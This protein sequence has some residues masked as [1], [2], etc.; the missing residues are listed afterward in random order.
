M[1]EAILRMAPLRMVRLMFR[2]KTFVPY[3][4]PSNL[5]YGQLQESYRLLKER[6]QKFSMHLCKSALSAFKD[7]RESPSALGSSEPN[8][9]L[10]LDLIETTKMSLTETEAVF[11]SDFWS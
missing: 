6:T 1:F 10:L 2:D 3:L 7:W 8:D 4:Q 11:E 9:H 5:E